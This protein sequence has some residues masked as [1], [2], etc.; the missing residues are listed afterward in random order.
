MQLGQISSQL[1]IKL[2]SSGHFYEN[3]LDS[4]IDKEIE[5][6]VKQEIEVFDEGG[7]K[8]DKEEEK[9]KTPN[10]EIEAK[11]RSNRDEKDMW[12]KSKNAS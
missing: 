11:N 6:E 10:K 3:M 12:N 2:R 4:P 5:R 7:V 8:K 9:C 1:A